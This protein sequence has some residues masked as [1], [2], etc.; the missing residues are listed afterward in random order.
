MKEYK[1]KFFNTSNPESI[2]GSFYNITSKIYE[3]CTKSYEQVP[4]NPKLQ[5]II[6]PLPILPFLQLRIFPTVY[7]KYGFNFNCMNE[8]F[9]IGAFLNL[10]IQAE[11]S[12]NMELGF[13][14]P[15]ANSLVELSISVGLKGVLGAGKVGLKL[16]YNLNH[17]HL[18]ISLD[19]RFESL[20]L[21][22]YIVFRIT[23]NLIEKQYIFEFNI[24]NQR[25][26]GLYKEWHK[27]IIY[28]FLK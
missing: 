21:Y 23:I 3:K 25:L 10:Y 5:P 18:A 26:F 19:Y 27:E 12:L 14:I 15:G 13:Y 28:K 22:F 16:E 6:I 2:F 1:D 17:N 11:V 7:L 4:I 20:T 24:V 9:E 8:K